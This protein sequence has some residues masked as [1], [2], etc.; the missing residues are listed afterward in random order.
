M[1]PIVKTVTGV[2]NSAWI[3]VNWRQEDFNISLGVVVS[4]TITYTIQ[5]TFD[6]IFDPDVTPVAFDHPTLAAQSANADDS[7]KEPVR[8]IR[9][10]NTAGTGSTTLTILQGR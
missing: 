2:A 5:H 4:G 1:R 9:I 3:P 10:S 7:Y 8:A 6:D